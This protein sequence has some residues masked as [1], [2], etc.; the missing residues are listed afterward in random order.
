MTVNQMNGNKGFNKIKG[1]DVLK[2]GFIFFENY[3]SIMTAKS[4]SIT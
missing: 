4:K 3:R 1:K 2:L